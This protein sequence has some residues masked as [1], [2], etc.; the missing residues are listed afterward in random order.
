MTAP[1]AALAAVSAAGW[2]V[3]YFPTIMSG[4]V[5]YFVRGHRDDSE[6][7]ASRDGVCVDVRRPMSLGTLRVALD[8]AERVHQALAAAYGRNRLRGPDDA[9]ACIRA[10][11]GPGWVLDNPRLGEEWPPSELEAGAACTCCASGEHGR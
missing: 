1:V 9:S 10:A 7:S 3:A 2:R 4:P 5:A 6:I 11:L 8:A